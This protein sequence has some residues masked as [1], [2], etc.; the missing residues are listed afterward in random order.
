MRVGFVG[1]GTMGH[2]MASCLLDA[3]HELTVNDIRREATTD[4]CERGAN[5]ADTPREV[6]QA[7]EVV[8]TSLP[9]PYEM[10]NVALDPETGLLAG[11]ATGSAYFDMST[12]SPAVVARVAEAFQARGIDLMDSPVSQRP[13][14]MTIMA[15]GRRETFD[16]Y[17]PVLDAMGRHVFYVGE[18]TKGCVAKLVTQHLGY[19]A[20]IAAAE[21]LLMA[22]KSGVDLNVLAQI[23]PVS[24]GASRAF[25]HYPRSVYDGEFP[26]IGS[27]DIVA[28]DLS[29]A[30]ELARELAVPSP[31]GDIADNVFKRAQA[32]GLGVKGFPA[33]VQILEQMADAEIRAPKET[34]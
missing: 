2:P 15:G 9:G 24:A 32:Q 33:A 29:L 25:D 22:A 1:T 17:K 6:A 23:V 16:K 21:G 31:I 14:N 5:W 8:F 27:L 20:F 4:L 7:S 12:N 10:Q 34:Q 19:T 28:K 13:P 3:G 11:L 26:S 30:C 18:S